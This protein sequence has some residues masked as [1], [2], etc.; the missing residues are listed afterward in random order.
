[1]PKSECRSTWA[2]W[3]IPGSASIIAYF[4]FSYGLAVDRSLSYGQMIVLLIPYI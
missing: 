1:M 2:I 3:L 4:L